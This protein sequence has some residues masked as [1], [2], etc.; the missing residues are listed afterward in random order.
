MTFEVMEYIVWIV[1]VVAT[2]FFN[3]EKT[4]AYEALTSRGL[5]QAYA[6]NYETTHTLGRE[7]IVGEIKDCLWT[8]TADA[9][10]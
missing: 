6:D 1:E 2:E 8:S 10:C 7:Y 3:G 9:P 4:A 5:I